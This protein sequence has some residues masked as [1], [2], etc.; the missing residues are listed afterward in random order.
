MPDDDFTN[1]PA[2]RILSD[3][4]RETAMDMSR[5]DLGSEKIENAQQVR[6][7]PFT[8][9]VSGLSAVQ[10]I[11]TSDV[12]MAYKTFSSCSFFLGLQMLKHKWKRNKNHLTG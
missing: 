6:V 11:R 2:K 1:L 10:V 7:L 3:S 12:S 4:S 5:V 9:F 8:F